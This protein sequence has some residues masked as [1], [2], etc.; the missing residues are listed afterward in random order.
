MEPITKQQGADAEEEQKD[1]E[2]NRIEHREG[3]K[4]QIK[5]GRR[6]YI[7]NDQYKYD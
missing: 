5:H 3:E 2:K 7:E 4:P 6:S 1:Q